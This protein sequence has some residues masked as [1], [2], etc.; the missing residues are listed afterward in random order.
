VVTA[1]ARVETVKGL[2]RRFQTTSRLIDHFLGAARSLLAAE[3][4]SPAAME[5]MLDWIEAVNEEALFLSA[6]AEVGMA[7]FNLA[8]LVRDAAKR[9]Y[10]RCSSV[11]LRLPELTDHQ[12]V[13]CHPQHLLDA[14]TMAM[15]MVLDHTGGESEICATLEQDRYFA[16]VRI[17]GR[18]RPGREGRLP[19]RENTARLKHLVVGL[20]QGT[21]VSDRGREG[22]VVI[23]IGLPLESLR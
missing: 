6:K 18:P 11:R 21:I 17:A 10:Q 1:R 12:A 20:H 23:T 9:V 22:E 5:R 15:D 8:Q 19:S 3:G 13:V 14:L 2:G 4:G 16:R 7:E